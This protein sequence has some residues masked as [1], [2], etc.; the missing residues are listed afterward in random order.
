MRRLLM[1][2]AAA[3]AVAG[4]IATTATAAH[5]DS[6]DHDRW[7]RRQE[8]DEDRRERRYERDNDR[9]ERAWEREQ[10]HLE[11]RADRWDRQ[12]HNGYYYHNRWHY[13]PPPVAYYGDP[14]FRPG[15]AAWRRGAVLPPYYRGA[16]L[17]EY[18][19]HRLR[20]PPPGYA[21]YRVNNDYVLT[22]TISGLIMEVVGGY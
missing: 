9:R 6:R 7:E 17:Y 11:R 16:Q 13:G 18:D 3:A 5:A 14:L 8:R 10:R 1:S 12:R 4:P 2:L 20:R 19:R 22:Q 15:Y 21:W